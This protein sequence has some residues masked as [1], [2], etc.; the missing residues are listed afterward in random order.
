MHF[1]DG[2]DQENK[3]LTFSVGDIFISLSDNIQE[4]FGL[5]PLEGMA[6]G[7]PVIVS[8][9]NGYRDTV[10]DK[11]NGFRVKTVS[12]SDGNGEDLAYSHMMGVLN[13][14]HY[15]GY[16]SQ[17]IA[18]DV[19]D[20]INKLILLIENKNLRRKLGNNAKARAKSVFDWSIILKEYN[21]LRDELNL[22]REKESI[23]YP[24]MCNKKLPSDRLDPFYLFSSYPSSI[25]NK[26]TN[27]Y[28]TKDI[29][30]LDID[31][32]YNLKSIE[33]ANPAIPDIKKIQ[34]VYDIV[35][36]R[37]STNIGIVSSITNINVKEI[38]RIIIWLIKF[39]YISLIEE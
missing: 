18:I 35:N 36:E 6:S 30:L 22:I 24:E 37:K 9:W 17:R 27:L 20:C 2:K 5:T 3:R 7:L 29:I 32:L 34:E 14:D 8:D 31:E 4:T 39:G 16:S 25:L 13:Y 15:I 38:Y 10:E 12:L 33:F 23:N 11:E 1:L 19:K 28:I 21:S 26:D